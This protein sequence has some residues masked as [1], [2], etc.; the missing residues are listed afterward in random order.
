MRPEC[1]LE[2]GCGACG[3]VLNPWQ[4]HD[5]QAHA[6]ATPGAAIIPGMQVSDLVGLCDAYRP[7]VYDTPG[8]EVEAGCYAA[9]WYDPTC[10]ELSGGAFGFIFHDENPFTL[11]DPRE[12]TASATQKARRAG[13][14]ITDGRRIG[15]LRVEA[16]GTCLPS[17]QYLAEWLVDRVTSN[18]CCGVEARLFSHCCTIDGKTGLRGLTDVRE[19]FVT[20]A[21][22]VDSYT[23]CGTVLDIYFTAG[24]LITFPDQKVVG[25]VD[26]PVEVCAPDCPAT[27]EYVASE[28][29]ASKQQCLVDLTYVADDDAV[30]FCLVNC[31]SYDQATQYLVPR[32]VA[33]IES[34]TDTCCPVEIS[35]LDLYS[36]QPTITPAQPSLYQTEVLDKIASGEGID[37]T[38]PPA[39]RTIRVANTNF[40]PTCDNCPEDIRGAGCA[41]IFGFTVSPTSGFITNAPA[42]TFTWDLTTNTTGDTAV[43]RWIDYLA[44]IGRTTPAAA[45]QACSGQVDYRYECDPFMTG[46]NTWWGFVLPDE[47]V[48]FDTG[49]DCGDPPPATTV[50]IPPPVAVEVT[51]DA[52]TGATCYRVLHNAVGGGLGTFCDPGRQCQVYVL[53]APGMNVPAGVEA[54]TIFGPAC[55]DSGDVQSTGPNPIETDVQ[56]VVNCVGDGLPANCLPWIDGTSNPTG[57]CVNITPAADGTFTLTYDANGQPVAGT[58]DIR[59]ASFQWLPCAETAETETCRPTIPDAAPFTLTF[60]EATSGIATPTGA[61]WTVGVG[62]PY[63]TAGTD[64][65]IDVATSLAGNTNPNVNTPIVTLGEPVERQIVTDTCPA[66]C[67]SFTP[68]TPTPVN[69]CAVCLDDDRALIIAKVDVSET[70]TYRPEITITAGDDLL[71]GLEVT[72]VSMPSRFGAPDTANLEPWLCG[73]NTIAVAELGVRE[74]FTWAGDCV[75]V[76]CGGGSVNAFDGHASTPDPFGRPRICDTDCAWLFVAYPCEHDAPVV[77][78]CAEPVT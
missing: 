46:S 24:D 43:D 42:G 49:I 52:A 40:D 12:L 11:Q 34:T 71:P 28:E 36:A 57:P 69:D 59:N 39:I 15:N 18:R 20:E 2:L 75:T 35:M 22:G 17:T 1:Y 60:N 76:T 27:T 64:Y 30:E 66:P 70:A 45:A 33:R 55:P 23:R 67:G 4:V 72:L 31:D 53:D 8:T 56:N 5:F 21:D 58:D 3:A 62:W 25:T 78:F 63:D 47:T 14:V 32:N 10:P 50:T 48:S 38:C 9:A 29:F 77:T 51:V 26:A 65:V 74:R 13:C 7:A 19:V 16:V 41:D 73:R 6:L 68:R 37:C 44:C 61:A 54:D